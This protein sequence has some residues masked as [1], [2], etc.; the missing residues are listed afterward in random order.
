MKRLVMLCSVL[1]ILAT[2]TFADGPE[3][4]VLTGKVTEASG[5]ALPGVM[6]TIEGPRGSQN[7]VTDGEGNYRFALLTP[8][9]YKIS[10]SLEGMQDAEGVGVISAGGKEE[11][12]LVLGLSTA[13]EI[14][15]TSE[16]PMVDKYDVSTGGTV[17][18]ETVGEVAAVF[19]GIYGAINVLPGVT[20]D[21]EST[22]L[23]SS[24]P[25]FNGSSWIES[26]VFVDGVDTTF[27]RYGATRMFLPTSATSEVSLTIE[28]KGADY[29]RSVGG[30]TNVIVKSGTNQFHG[31]AGGTYQSLKWDSNFEPHPELELPD[32]PRLA[33]PAD[34]FALTG[35]E[36]DVDQFNYDVSVGGPLKRDKAWFFIGAADFGTFT[37]DRTLNGDLIDQSTDVE[38]YIGKF[39]FQP[40][41]SH[42]LAASWIATPITRLFQTATFADQYVPT[43]HDIGG[44]LISGTWNW[45]ISSSLFLE[46]KIAQHTSS[47]DK[48]LAACFCTDPAE[49][50]AVKQQDPRF[51]PVPGLTSPDAPVNNYDAYLD[52]ISGTW[53][54]GW[55]LDNGFGTNEY[56][57]DQFNVSLTQFA[58]ANNELRYGIDWQETHWEQDVSRGSFYYGSFFD[59]ASS[60]GFAAPL[61]RIDYNPAD[62][63]AAGKGTGETTGENLGIFIRDRLTVGDHWTF[64]LGLRLEDSVQKNDIGRKV[65]DSQDLSPRFTG[66]YD[67]K[68]DGRMLFTLSAGRYYTH[69]PQEMVNSF[70]LDEWNGFNAEDRYFYVAPFGYVFPIGSV[71][72]GRLWDLHDQGV[73]N[74]D[75]DPYGRDEAV[76]GFEWQ[77]SDN[78]AFSAK[79][80]FWE[81]FDQITSQEQLDPTANCV[82]GDR[83]CAPLFVISENVEDVP[84]TL[85]QLGWVDAFVEDCL[86][87]NREGV[88]CTA[89]HANSILDN[90][91]PA[92]R[93]YTA[94]Q[95]QLNR[96]FRDGWA[97]YNH[98]TLSD[99]EGSIFG[100]R[101]NNTDDDFGELLHLTLTESDIAGCE[102]RNASNGGDRADDVACGDLRQFIGQ[103]V[104]TVNR[105]GTAERERDMIFRSYGY[106][107]WQFGSSGHSF[108]LGGQFTFQTGVK[109]NYRQSGL[110]AADRNSNNAADNTATLF[111]EPRGSRELGS[112]AWTNLNLAY[113][114]PLPGDWSGTARLE[115]TNVENRQDLIGV[116]EG[117][118]VPR[119]NK[120]Y[121]TQPRKIRFTFNFRF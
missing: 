79:G 36:R 67:V 34:F 86:A 81:T 107:T 71:R 80:I 12:N 70:L 42:S 96:R 89:E 1:L 27:T 109:W 44:S 39:N 15:V 88:P 83:S 60:S 40:S 43:M 111:V 4:G 35:E 95:L 17:Q 92:E 8:G 29:G 26:A 101:F 53:H 7:V 120:R 113:G 6:V 19:K 78:W 85:R 75:I 99:A 119:A 55:I 112:H 121:W 73:I 102:S 104:S 10:A 54:N 23:S 11:V 56:P 108:T 74:V 16:A 28:G 51:A 105:F 69:I 24:R 98:V 110:E 94:A 49:A 72:P 3:T 87:N 46:S 20:N 31:D 58:G 64:N 62:V 106:K 47:E 32:D 65:I 2:P 37:R 93:K 68:G 116:A 52:I 38:S 63:V 25:S 45:S 61:V 117:S 77:F 9:S 22:D 41:Q 84:D 14:T 33:R 5:Q 118:G 18:A 57:R 66:V 13:E 50:L 76:I 90:L 59:A 115:V 97:L 100:S 30:V 48:L 114:F 103:P 91:A 82:A 21:Q